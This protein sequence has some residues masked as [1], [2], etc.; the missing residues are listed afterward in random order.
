VKTVSLWQ[1]AGVDVFDLAVVSAHVAGLQVRPP[2]WK[3]AQIEIDAQ[4]VSW[5]QFAEFADDGG[6]S[7]ARWW[8]PEGWAWVQRTGRHY[9]RHIAQLQN[10]VLATRFGKLTRVPQTH[11][12]THVSW[13]EADAWCR[14]AGRRLPTEAEWERAALAGIASGF[15]W[16]QVWEWTASAFRPYPGFG[17]DPYRDYS[18]PWFDT[19]KVLRGSSA[20]TRARMRHVRYRNFYAP[21]R[22]DIFNGFRSCAL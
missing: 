6:Y 8:S 13:Y 20:A 7:D 16:G 15:R 12:A 4:T 1:G 22:D 5:A 9:P 10:G 2:K 18:Q 14:W 11:P 19:H 17:A 21:E 3:G